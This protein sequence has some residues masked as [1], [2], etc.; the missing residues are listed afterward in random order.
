V[1]IGEGLLQRKARSA[2]SP[3]SEL[4][5]PG[6]GPFIAAGPIMGALS[7]VGLRLA[8]GGITEALIGLGNPEYEAKR[9]EG[10]INGGHILLSVHAE[11]LIGLTRR[12]ASL[13]TLRL[14]TSRRVL[15]RKV[16]SQKLI[17]LVRDILA[18]IPRSRSGTPGSFYHAH[19]FR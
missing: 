9:Y 1:R 15:R 13:R 4:A 14:K 17:D 6:L 11:I 8:A 10:R 19:D 7:G 12:N 3:E 16:T 18:K 2:G 5:V